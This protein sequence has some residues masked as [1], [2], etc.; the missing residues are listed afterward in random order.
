[1]NLCL[2]IAFA[3]ILQ[4][5]VQAQESRVVK[6]VVEENIG[7]V[8]PNRLTQPSDPLTETGKKFAS[9]FDVPDIIKQKSFSMESS[10]KKYEEESSEAKGVTVLGPLT[11]PEKHEMKKYFKTMR[12][13][14]STPD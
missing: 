3:V 7:K 1:M 8:T 14:V 9:G 2:W 10:R 11:E 13:P 6:K 5:Q 4:W 12:A